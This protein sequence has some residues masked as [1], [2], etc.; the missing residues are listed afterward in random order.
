MSRQIK[1]ISNNNAIHRI[2]VLFLLPVSLALIF[3][4]SIWMGIKWFLEGQISAFKGLFYETHTNFEYACRK[5][6][7]RKF[8]NW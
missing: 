1:K 7:N 8:W 3:I 5:Y 4:D 2:V 6:M